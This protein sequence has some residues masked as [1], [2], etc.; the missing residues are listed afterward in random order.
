MHTS[1]EQAAYN[2]AN[3]GRDVYVGDSS[4]TCSSNAL[5][6]YPETTTTIT[7]SC[8]HVI[9]QS[10]VPTVVAACPALST[11]ALCRA[12]SKCQFL[13]KVCFQDFTWLQVKH[14]PADS[15]N[16]FS[17]TDHLAGTHEAGTEG[18]NAAEWAI[19][20]FHLTF[21]KFL[22][23][24]GDFENWLMATKDQVNGSIY[25]LTK[26]TA[27]MS[28]ASQTPYQVEWNN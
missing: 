15:S 11:A 20:F 7:S 6:T 18:T 26:R 10:Y 9:A 16:W 17:G 13:N 14:L 3:F 5:W 28:S 27:L 1:G 23:V 12:D 2:L 24:H 19:K 4:Q 25:A 22:F 21:D 8:V